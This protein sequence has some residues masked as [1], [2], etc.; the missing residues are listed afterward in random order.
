M[1]SASYTK[2]KVSRT[3]TLHLRLVELRNC[4]NFSVFSEF[5]I[6]VPLET[7]YSDMFIKLIHP[8]EQEIVSHHSMSVPTLI[9]EEA[10]SK[11]ELERSDSVKQFQ[12]VRHYC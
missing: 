1:Y 3:I 10:G 11:A 6:P 8:A 9:L 4:V 7:T 12:K 5:A 2:L